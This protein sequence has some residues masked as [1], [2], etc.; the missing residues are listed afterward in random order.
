M[1]GEVYTYCTSNK[2][3]GSCVTVLNQ[4]L[5]LKKK[6]FRGIPRKPPVVASFPHFSPSRNEAGQSFRGVFVGIP[7][8]IAMFFYFPAS[9]VISPRGAGFV[10]GQDVA[11]KCR[12]QK[13]FGDSDVFFFLLPFWRCRLWVFVRFVC[14]ILRSV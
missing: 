10:F 12:P 13:T 1:D 9:Q 7:Q 6:D 5:D 4:R 2:N 8:G 14:I 3:L 11:W